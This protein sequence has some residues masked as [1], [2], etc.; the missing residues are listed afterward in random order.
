MRV[1]G[2]QAWRIPS[3]QRAAVTFEPH[4]QHELSTGTRG[5]RTLQAMAKDALQRLQERRE[6]R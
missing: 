4:R 1:K 2:A 5:A 6:L 3:V